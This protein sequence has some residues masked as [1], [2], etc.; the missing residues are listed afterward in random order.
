MSDDLTTSVPP[1][2]PAPPPVDPYAA[3]AAPAAPAASATEPVRVTPAP[4]RTASGGRFLNLLLG[5][6]VAVAIGGVAFAVGRSTAPAAASGFGRGG[7]FLSGNGLPGGSFDPNPAGAPGQGGTGQGRFGGGFGGLTISG[8]VES[9]S[10]DTLTIKTASGQ[11]IEVTTSSDTA[12]HQEAAATAADVTTGT[13]VK[14]QVDFSGRGQGAQ[15]GQGGA[16]AGTVG[17]ASDVTVVP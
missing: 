4:K 11:T 9:V 15:G 12:Y 8:T 17:T 5:V 3:P 16:T 10:G 7:T 13:T 2:T 6:A 14:V 1:I